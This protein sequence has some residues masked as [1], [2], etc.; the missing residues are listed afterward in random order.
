[1]K[2]KIVILGSTGSIGKNTISIIKKDMDSYQVVL[3]TANKNISLLIKQAKELNVK[4]LIITDKKKYQIAKKKYRKLNLK[5][6][7]SFEIINQIFSFKEIYYTMVSVVGIN[8]LKPTLDI[9]KYTKNIAIANKESIICGWKLISDRLLKFKTNFLPIDSEHYSIYLLIHKKDIND[10]EK[11]YITASGG[12]FNNYKRSRLSKVT[13]SEALQ[14]PNWKMGK[15]ISIDSATLMNKVFEVIE[16]RNIF[17]ISYK[18]I[19]ILIH[20]KSYVHAIVKFRNGISKLL[21]HNPDMKI[22]IQNSLYPNNHNRFKNKILD[23]KTLNNLSFEK[24]DYKKFPLA[25]ILKKLPKYN[26]LYETALVTIND[27]FVSKFLNKQINY[28]E[29]IKFIDQYSK[30]Q[31]FV[32]LKKK[33]V[34]KAD[35]IYK[36]NK[37][38]YLKLNSLSI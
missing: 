25:N 31:E 35:Q 1:M 33:H 26:S 21:I 30:L 19:E 32:K 9:I 10:I 4:N 18:N 2:K 37:Y 16:A 20:P 14:H 8:G 3:L 27:F 12:P 28:L 7:N 17:G 15:K 36:L 6:F 13:V 24:L 29:L 23:F 34:K 5:I 38:V 22:P 11:I